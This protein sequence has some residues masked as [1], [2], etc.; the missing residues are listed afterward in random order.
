MLIKHITI[1]HFNSYIRRVIYYK[2]LNI[3]NLRG[4]LCIVILSWHDV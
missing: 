4:I 2:I 3:F 1:Y